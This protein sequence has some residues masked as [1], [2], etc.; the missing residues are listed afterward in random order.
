MKEDPLLSLIEGFS[1]ESYVEAALVITKI[2]VPIAGFPPP[3]VP[4]KNFVSLASIT[5]QVAKEVLANSDDK[6]KEAIVI[7]ENGERIIIKS[8]TEIYV[9]VLKINIWNGIIEDEIENFTEKVASL[10]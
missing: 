7:S 1:K 6:F 10:L 8:L 5:A 2:G 9:L 3:E 4:L